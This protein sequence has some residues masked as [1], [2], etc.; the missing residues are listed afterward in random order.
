M[1]EATKDIN[2]ALANAVRC[3]DREGATELRARRNELEHER[4]RIQREVTELTN[5]LRKR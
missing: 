2:F 1:K 3:S 4:L 5:S